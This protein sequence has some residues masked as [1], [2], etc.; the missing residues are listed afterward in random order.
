M[1]PEQF[2]KHLEKSGQVFLQFSVDKK[3]WQALSAYFQECFAH[4]EDEDATRFLTYLIDCAAGHI[5][6]DETRLIGELMDRYS[7][8]CDGIDYPTSDD[9]QVKNRAN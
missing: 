7:A 3:D 8:M 2:R 1:T 9:D 4:K 5:G 6:S